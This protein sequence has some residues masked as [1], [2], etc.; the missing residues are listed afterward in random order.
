MA[1]VS[2][3]RA[4][5][6]RQLIGDPSEVAQDLAKF[7]E[8][9]TALSSAHPRFIEKY[10][11]KWVAVLANKKVIASDSLDVL[12]GQLDEKGISREHVIVRFIDRSDRTLF[13]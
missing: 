9:A 1:T 5:Q 7:R 12:L 10:P 2:R 4:Q 11:Q 3:A 8:A 13:L 6:L